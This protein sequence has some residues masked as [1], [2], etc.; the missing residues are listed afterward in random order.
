MLVSR[1]NNTSP[2]W[3]PRYSVPSN[4]HLSEVE[5]RKRAGLSG[6]DG[7]LSAAGESLSFLA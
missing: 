4:L 6:V 7:S 2:L 3:D 5:I 1:M